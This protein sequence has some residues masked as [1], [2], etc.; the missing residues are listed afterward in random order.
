[1]ARGDLVWPEA[2]TCVRELQT[3][4]TS[5][6]DINTIARGSQYC[7]FFKGQ[8]SV[9]LRAR[10]ALGGLECGELGPTETS[11]E[12]PISGCQRRRNLVRDILGEKRN[13]TYINSYPRARNPKETRANS[14]GDT[15]GEDRLAAGVANLGGSRACWRHRQCG[16]P[17]PPNIF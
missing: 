14:K 1:M 13:K 10:A 17:P 16:P 3:H 4:Q 9:S 5:P 11:P 2:S 12:T 15:S 7:V 6:H 8:W